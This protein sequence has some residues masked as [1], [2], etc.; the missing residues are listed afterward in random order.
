[1]STPAPPLS[2][3]RRAAVLALLIA[4]SWCTVLGLY[5]ATTAAARWLG[6]LLAEILP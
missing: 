3:R 5:H 2:L 6:T 1:M 4:L